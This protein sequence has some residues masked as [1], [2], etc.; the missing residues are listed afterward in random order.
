MRRDFSQ[1]L[2]LIGAHAILHQLTRE[3]D[4][5]GRVVATLDDYRTVAQLVGGVFKASVSSGATEQVRE[6]VRAVGDVS[7]N[8]GPATAAAG[9]GRV[10]WS[11]AGAWRRLCS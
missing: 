9:G 5:A 11:C 4:P 8:G 7:A 3:T 2:T 10:A 1:L 6:A